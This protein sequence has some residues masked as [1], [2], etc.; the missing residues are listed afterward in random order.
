VDETRTGSPARTAWGMVIGGREVDGVSGE[1][2]Q[3][4]NPGTGEVVGTFPRGEPADVARA[5]EAARAAFDEGPW[6]RT[7]GGERGAILHRLA[8]RLRARAGEYARL[9][10]RQVGI[11]YG[12][13]AWLNSYCADVVD[14]YAGGARM[15]FGRSLSTSPTGLGITLPQPVG[16]VAAITPWNFPLVLTIW[17]VAAALAAGCTMVLKPASQTPVTVVEL[18]L[19]L[20][21]SGLPPGVCNVVTGPGSVVGEALTVHPG[22]DKVAFTGSTETGKEI[23]ARAAG[24]LKR[25]SLELGGKSPMIVLPDADSEA[26]SDAL[27][28]CFYNSGQ[29][30]NVPSRLVVAKEIAEDLVDQLVGKA[31]RKRLGTDDD[32]DLGPLV[33]EAQ[34]AKVASLVDEA[35]ASGAHIRTGGVRARVKGAGDAPFMPPT[36]VDGVRDDAPIVRQE[37]FGPV[38]VVQRFDQLED[39]IRVA[40]TGDFGLAAGIFTDNLDAALAAAK[41]LRAGTVWIN[42]WNKTFPELPTGGFKASGM[43]RELG[44]EGL[45]AYLE[46]K[47]VQFNPSGRLR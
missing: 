24:T 31:E 46:V 8:E 38:L 11:P 22:V 18:A 39:A 44:L 10:S 28:E 2:Y 35:R 32:A 9:E 15:A 33:D 47:T 40:N 3:R 21:E 30:C 41:L 16:V 37:V 17:K 6:P 26:A 5:V 20:L 19:D 29:Q 13:I 42:T 36:V 7:T 1:T 27:L 14:F 23:M 4:K 43:G 34:F 25:V 45:S 12:Q